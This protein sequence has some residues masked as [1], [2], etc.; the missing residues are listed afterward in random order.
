M[1]PYKSVQCVNC[2]LRPVRKEI[3]Y[4]SQSFPSFISEKATGILVVSNNLDDVATI[5]PVMKEPMV[6]SLD[7]WRDQERTY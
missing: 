4:P 7:P 5:Y 2:L 6:M 1:C 3:Q